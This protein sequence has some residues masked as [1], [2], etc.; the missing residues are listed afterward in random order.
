MAKRITLLTVHG[1]GETSDDYYV[2]LVKATRD[3]LR[4]TAQLVE[5]QHV[6][7]QRSL[8]QNE[9]YIWDQMTRNGHL[10]YPKIRKFLLFGFA[11][12]AGLETRKELPGS[13]Y[14]EAQVEIAQKLWKAWQAMEK[15]G[16]VV[17]I[18][19]SLG[20]QVISNYLYD[21]Q[22]DEEG[23]KRTAGIWKSINDFTAMIK[24]SAEPF[25]E[26]EI[27]FL[28]GKTIVGLITTGCNIPVFI[29]AHK[30][31]DI[32]PIRR[33][34]ERFT[35]LNYYDKHDPLGWPLQPL[36]DEYH[37]LVK[38]KP[39]NAARHNPED[40]LKSFT[41]WSHAFYWEDDDVI[42][43]TAELI[44]SGLTKP[45]TLASPRGAATTGD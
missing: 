4:A 1:M 10:A 23:H 20:S 12:A 6:Y 28:R 3:K 43:G 11:D 36:S 29:A 42:T 41:P 8:Q 34:S 35:W 5:F 19:Q 31:L 15:P 26:E 24:G 39:I 37:E 33:P 27:A 18:A 45:V 30:K 25:T 38:D 44:K 9:D 7:Y 40:Y 2:D 32:K 22:Q 17:V 16:R 14:E 13:V 21:A